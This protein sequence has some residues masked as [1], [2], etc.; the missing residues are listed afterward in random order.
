MKK[1]IIEREVP[2][3]GKLTP[4]ELKAFSET[5]CNVIAELDSPYLWVQ[6]FVTDTK[7]YCIHIAP[8][9]ETI[10]EHAKRGGFPANRV[11]EVKSMIDS[12][13]SK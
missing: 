3:T 6:T 12:T 1:F 11:L 4:A 10:F 9:E 2:G 13:T 8:D 7:L 5:S